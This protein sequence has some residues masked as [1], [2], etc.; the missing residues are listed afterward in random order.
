[1]LDLMQRE[2]VDIRRLRAGDRLTLDERTAVEVLW[3]PPNRTDLTA[4]DTSLVLR[5]SC[6]GKTVLLPGD[7][8]EVGMQELLKTPEKLKADALIIPHHGGWEKQLPAFVQAV[9]PKIVLVSNSRDPH[10]PTTAGPKTRDFYKLLHKDYQYYSTARNGWIQLRFA[11][12]RLE[13]ETMR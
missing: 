1:M 2:K 8:S 6:D 12:G 3:P 7:L 5:V 13:V 10:G 11:S 4:N 9:A